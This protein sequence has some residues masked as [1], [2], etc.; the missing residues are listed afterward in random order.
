M[1]KI[2]ELWRGLHQEPKEEE[3]KLSRVFR[4][5]VSYLQKGETATMDDGWVDWWEDKALRA[6][7]LETANANLLGAC[8]DIVFCIEDCEECEGMGIDPR[9]E[10]DDACRGCGGVG[11]NLSSDGIFAAFK[12]QEAIRKHKGEGR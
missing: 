7:Q 8:K 9:C 2:T 6:E 12:A 3:W 10:I 1:N 11:K 4:W 5:V